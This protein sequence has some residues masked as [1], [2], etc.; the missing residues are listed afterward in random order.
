MRHSVRYCRLSRVRSL[1]GH[2]PSASNPPYPSTFPAERIAIDSHYMAVDIVINW[3]AEGVV[4]CFLHAVVDIEPGDNDEQNKT[5]WSNWCSTYGFGEQ[6]SL[7][8][9]EMTSR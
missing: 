2:V 5:G 1:L 6:V 8:L 3:V 9:H 4:L 7:F